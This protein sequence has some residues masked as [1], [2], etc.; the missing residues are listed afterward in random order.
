MKLVKFVGTP[1]SQ[2]NTERLLL[3]VAVSIIVKGELANKTVNYQKESQ[4]ERTGFKSSR[5]QTSN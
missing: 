2:S 4:S 1:F 3:I 5:S